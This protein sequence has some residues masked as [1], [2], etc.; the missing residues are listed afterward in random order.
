MQYI[1]EVLV[2]LTQIPC[3]LHTYYAIYIRIK[4]L[5]GEWWRLRDMV[6]FWQSTSPVASQS[7]PC[8]PLLS[9]FMVFFDIKSSK[10]CE[11]NLEFTRHFLPST[12]SRS[13][14]RVLIPS[15]QRR[16]WNVRVSSVQFSHSVVSD[17][18]RPR[19]A[20]ARQA[21]LSIT[22][23]RSLLRLMSEWLSLKSQWWEVESQ[24]LLPFFQLWHH[25][26]LPCPA[27]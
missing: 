3:L 13:L 11:G 27:I 15:T 21:S 22:S 7:R 17:S 24:A 25:A 9:D 20:A 8:I 19:G 1:V 26:F 6:T 12:S 4:K 14:P 10:Q 16:R 2:I 5:V 23:S 18:S